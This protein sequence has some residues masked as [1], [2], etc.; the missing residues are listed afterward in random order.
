MVKWDKLEVL[1]LEDDDFTRR[2]IVQLLRQ[3]GV[4]LTHQARNGS[5]GLDL[6]RSPDNKINLVLCDL[7]MPD[8]DG[9][10]FARAVRHADTSRMRSVK[11]LVATAQSSK[12]SVEKA[13]G[14]GIDGYVLKPFSLEQLRLRIEAVF[15][16]G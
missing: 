11:I 7:G 14:I 9:F 2:I 3:L 6:L 8:V 16:D 10:Q 15:R 12:E 13:R 4:G 5:E 1:V